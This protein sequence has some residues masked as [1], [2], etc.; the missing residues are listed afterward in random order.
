M[1]K[2]GVNGFGCLV[3]RAAFDSGKE[4]IVAI[5]D[6]FIDLNYMVT[7]SSMTLP[8]ASAKAHFKTENGKLIIN[9][10]VITVFQERDPTNIKWR[11]ASTMKLWYDGRGATQNIIPAPTGAAKAVG[12]VIPEL[13]GKLMDMAFHVPTPSVSVMDLTCHLE[14]AAT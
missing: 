14:K 12:K 10:K 9:R 1:V 8:M 13:N 5:N 6:P 2:V 4:D 3:A 7:C 11:D